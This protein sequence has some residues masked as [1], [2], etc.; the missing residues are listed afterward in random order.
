MGRRS[1]YTASTEVGSRELARET[2]PGRSRSRARQV[3]AHA[4]RRVSVRIPAA[5]SPPEHRLVLH[6]QPSGLAGT[7]TKLLQAAAAR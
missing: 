3:E 4:M 6:R 1:S 2:R 5:R 7:P